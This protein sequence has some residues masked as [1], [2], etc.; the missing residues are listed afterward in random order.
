[1][2]T[3]QKI[4]LCTD[5]GNSS[6]SMSKFLHLSALPRRRP[7]FSRPIEQ[8]P[9]V[10]NIHS[11]NDGEDGDSDDEA[12]GD[13]TGVPAA[14]PATDNPA[15]LLER[16]RREILAMQE[17]IAQ[18]ERAQ[19]EASGLAGE[20]RT[21]E[22]IAP[23][24]ANHRPLPAN[25]ASTIANNNVHSPDPYDVNSARSNGKPAGSNSG[26][27][28]TTTNGPD[29]DVAGREAY[30]AQLRMKL[31]AMQSHRETLEQR[32]EQTATQ[33]EEYRRYL[34]M[35]EHEHRTVVEQL[36]QQWARETE[37]CKHIEVEQARLEVL[38]TLGRRK[39]H[40]EVS[41]PAA[42][43][44]TET[45]GNE[46]EEGEVAVKDAEQEEVE[47]QQ[48]EEEEEEGECLPESVDWEPVYQQMASAS[49]PASEE[50]A[51]AKPPSVA[52]FASS[53][54]IS[55][56]SEP[57][58]KGAGETQNGKGDACRVCSFA[59]ANPAAA[60]DA[61]T[62]ALD[63][64]APL[65]PASSADAMPVTDTTDSKMDVDQQQQYIDFQRTLDAGER[66][67]RE[68]R[69]GVALL[70]R[71]RMAKTDMK[72]SPMI[73]EPATQQ[74]TETGT[75]TVSQLIEKLTAPA[76][77]SYM[78]MPAAVE[79][80]PAETFES[81][82]MPFVL[83]DGIL[84]TA[85]CPLVCTLPLS[86]VPAARKH[87]GDWMIDFEPTS[88]DAPS[89]ANDTSAAIL[90]EAK[91][92]P[93]AKWCLFEASG[94]VCRDNSCFSMHLR[95][96]SFN[97]KELLVDLCAYIRGE[98]QAEQSA[99]TEQ[100]VDLLRSDQDV[101]TITQKLL[102]LQS[103]Y[104]VDDR[105]S[106][107]FNRRNEQVRQ[108]LATA[109]SAK[110]A[111][112]AAANTAKQSSTA[113][114][115]TTAPSHAPASRVP[116]IEP[117]L[118]P[119]HLTMLQ[120]AMDGDGGSERNDASHHRYYA[121]DACTTEQY[122]AMLADQPDRVDVWIA[123]AQHLLPRPLSADVLRMPGTQ[124]DDTLRILSRALSVHPASEA[125]W[126]TYLELIMRRGD[127][128]AVE[129]L[130]EHALRY[131]NMAWSIRWRHYLWEKDGGRKRALLGNMANDLV[132]ESGWLV[133]LLLLEQDAE[134]AISTLFALLGCTQTTRFVSLI[135]DGTNVDALSSPALTEITTAHVVAQLLQP[136]HLTLLSTVYCHLLLWHCL[137]QDHLLYA[138][139]NDF[140]VTGGLLLLRYDRLNELPLGT[141][142]NS[143]VL[144]CVYRTWIALMRY[145]L[146][147][148]SG[149]DGASARAGKMPSQPWIWS[150]RAAA[151]NCHL[152]ARTFALSD[153][154]LRELLDGAR[155]Q[156]MDAT[157]VDL[158]TE[159]EQDA[160]QRADLLSHV[161][162]RQKEQ[163]R[164][165]RKR[166]ST[167]FLH[168]RLVVELLSLSASTNDADDAKAQARDQILAQ[169]G[170]CVRGYFD[171]QLVQ[172]HTTPQQIELLY[173][174]LLGLA[175]PVNTVSVRD[176][177]DTAK[178]QTDIYLWLNYA[179]L[180]QLLHGH[181]SDGGET[182]MDGLFRQ[183]FAAI[184]STSASTTSYPWEGTLY[185][186]WQM[187][188]A[189]T[190]DHRHGGAFS[191]QDKED[192][193]HFLQSSLEQAI[194]QLVI[195]HEHRYNPRDDVAATYFLPLKDWTFVN[196]LLDQC[197]ELLPSMFRTARSNL[198]DALKGNAHYWRVALIV[199]MMA[200]AAAAAV[201][202]Y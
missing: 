70:Q 190:I 43:T 71:A 104:R 125:L 143:S 73:R 25:A 64:A 171:Q 191:D 103:N 169:L 162:Q 161:I 75:A 56:G 114:S 30:L 154:D 134:T 129:N 82:A 35:A 14:Q 152:L 120:Q 79:S 93:F 37:L 74:T 196:G 119:I 76:R 164:Q 155:N 42:S 15:V 26:S 50:E 150:F 141:R 139:P 165:S 175:T 17:R 27:S 146:A 58:G 140:V 67:L 21:S 2:V 123:Y 182:S 80:I 85:D 167:S 62:S 53:M 38:R 149:G 133:A 45:D 108:L 174:K 46:L 168:Y 153:G 68:L 145:L 59:N 160:K 144:V 72:M 121:Q 178:A 28:T 9:V 116:S 158:Y 138:V 102:E 126:N 163:G 202:D 40:S 78:S 55:T 193:A 181:S 131:T 34:L 6:T 91:I 113:T 69:E 7:L 47:E 109:L 3:C 90:K 110:H 52:S 100:L 66:S 49:H 95:D 99:Y 151:Q 41:K 107:V 11:D 166:M 189:W 84:K 1:M 187:Y 148:P 106:I 24:E 33:A 81:T 198:H 5:A 87:S 83:V 105:Q 170:D 96:I 157:L 89:P 173:R 86:L 180:V 194:S 97:D 4:V 130:V 156:W 188:I 136:I 172:E 51:P 19:L 77:D 201:R 22:D 112:E 88:S 48:Q 177:I 65:P 183:M 54:D 186:L 115:D 8:R 111:K 32:V 132:F 179:F 124:L 185:T 98:T 176:G 10:I 31:T 135:A 142:A 23:A 184:G 13:V 39:A 101:G 94:G 57:D 195:S 127:H 159:L 199:V 137:P 117:M 122:E 118:P 192:R 147:G 12:G 18:L 36:E 61:T 200:A 29:K 128:T 60:Q 20:N 16:K 44:T 92:D 63:A 197:M